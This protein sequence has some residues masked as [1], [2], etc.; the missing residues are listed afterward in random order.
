MLARHTSK[1][2]S[3]KLKT[4]FLIPTVA[5]SFPI[6]VFG[7]SL[8]IKLDNQLNFC[9]LYIAFC[10][11]GTETCVRTPSTSLPKLSCCHTGASLFTVFGTSRLFDTVHLISFT[12]YRFYFSSKLCFSQFLSKSQN[13]FS[14]ITGPRTCWIRVSSWHFIPS[15]STDLAWNIQKHSDLNG[16]AATLRSPDF[17]NQPD[18]AI[19]THCSSRQSQ[20][21]INFSYLDLSYHSSALGIPRY[22]CWCATRWCSWWSPNFPQTS[23]SK[24][25]GSFR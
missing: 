24:L 21:Q 3:W 6:S 8:R 19:N 12:N 22:P 10:K 5:Q 11:L 13:M 1:L 7:S 4:I 2:W 9:N 15:R 17:F 25:G 18:S 14:C 20:K 23:S 16:T